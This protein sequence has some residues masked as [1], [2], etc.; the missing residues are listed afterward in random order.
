MKY[1]RLKALIMSKL[2]LNFPLPSSFFITQNEN[3]NSD[4]NESISDD[5]LRAKYVASEKVL[6]LKASL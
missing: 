6:S 5:T 1:K 4:G 2:L 3:E